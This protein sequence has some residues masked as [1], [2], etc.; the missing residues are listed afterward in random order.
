MNFMKLF[1]SAV[2]YKKDYN[3]LKMCDPVNL[4]LFHFGLDV[5]AQ[6]TYKKCN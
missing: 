3:G 1:L 5:C 2:S 4:K 6:P